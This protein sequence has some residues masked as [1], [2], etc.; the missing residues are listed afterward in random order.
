MET[1]KMHSNIQFLAI[2]GLCLD[3]LDSA[4]AEY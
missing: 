2:L 4:L 3:K 1:N